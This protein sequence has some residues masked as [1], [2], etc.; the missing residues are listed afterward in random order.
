MATTP[1]NPKKQKTKNK[2]STLLLWPGLI[3]V[4]ETNYE[5]FELPTTNNQILFFILNAFTG[6]LFNLFLNIGVYFTSP[7]HM[8]V[9]TIVAI[10]FS[11]FVD[12]LFGNLELTVLKV[13]GALLITFGYGLF[14]A[15]ELVRNKRVREVLWFDVDLGE[16]ISSLLSREGKRR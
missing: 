14:T 7:L 6:F 5:K 16:K 10:P 3:I 9:A 11:F 2:S 15:V 8:K 12:F 13:C 4:S 1:T